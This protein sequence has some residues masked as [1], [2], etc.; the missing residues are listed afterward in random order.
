MAQYAVG[1]L[2]KGLPN[3]LDLTSSAPVLFTNAIV[4]AASLP[5]PIPSGCVV[6]PWLDTTQGSISGISISS[7]VR[8]PVKGS[9]AISVRLID[10]DGALAA[11]FARDPGF[12]NTSFWDLTTTSVDATT[13]SLSVSG[14][15]AIT[16]RIYWLEQE[17]VLVT[18]A[19]VTTGIDWALTVTRGANGS[20][21]RVHRINPAAY[22]PGEDGAFDMVSLSSRPQFE[23]FTFDADLFLM[24]IEQ[25]GVVQVV[26]TRAG[27][28]DGRPEP[29]GDAR[30]DLSLGDNTSIVADHDFGE[31]RENVT[32]RRCAQV[33]TQSG[34]PDFYI[35]PLQYTAPFIKLWVDGYEAE[36]IFNEPLH[37]P[38]NDMPVQ[39]LVNALSAKLTQDA[40]VRY[41]LKMK[42]GGYD[43]VYRATKLQWFPTVTNYQ[44]DALVVVFCA[45]DFAPINSS[46]KDNPYVSFES[47]LSSS[48]R[49]GLNSGF[50]RAAADY[51]Q[52][53]EEK[54]EIE[55]RVGIR[56][57]VVN[58]LLRL[59]HSDDGSQTTDPVYD[60]IFGRI[61]AGLFSGE[62]NQGTTPANP[63]AV[64]ETT[65]ELLELNALLPQPF[66]FIITP[67]DKFKD[68]LQNICRLHTLLFG[69]IPTSG[70]LALRFWFTFTAPASIATLNPIVSSNDLPSL[71]K[72]E[73]LA[74]VKVDV[75]Y[76]EIDLK[77]PFS[78]FVIRAKGASQKTAGNTQS[79]RL[80]IK[81][82]N[83]N[84]A[85]FV[86]SQVV[87]RLT[88]AFFRML[89]GQPEYILTATF[90]P[91]AVRTF[92]DLVLY[93]DATALLPTP[94]G[95]GIDGRYIVAGIDINLEDGRQ[96]LRLLP[97]LI[98]RT[99]SSA[100]KIA[101]SLVI[102]NVVS[103]SGPVSGVY[104]VDCEV[105]S[106]A[107][108]AFDITTAHEGIWQEL[109]NQTGRVRLY[110][111]QK[112]NPVSSSTVGVERHGYLEASALVS[113][114]LHV[115]GV[116]T[117]AIKIDES[118][119]RSGA[120]AIGDLAAAG[121]YIVLT[122]RRFAT[123]NVENVSISP[124]PFQYYDGGA[125][126]DFLKIAPSSATPPFD[127]HF[128]E[129][130]T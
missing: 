98:S 99:S 13:T 2:I 91:G 20:Y 127:N 29:T 22:G 35:S 39:S 84:F 15:A 72:L 86:M 63:Y 31:A 6:L 62:V 103:I 7:D 74:Q 128:S 102:T 121:N 69:C 108:A 123:S 60:T 57:S 51:L 125:G 58:T 77:P 23:S 30:W 126:A 65:T 59:L 49:F 40:S 21:A 100:G 107:E 67:K 117:I 19:S 43:Y 129:I 88:Q 105:D 64:E 26:Y 94:L 78:P 80:W 45:L 115:A 96:R 68:W 130:S 61:G 44:D 28:I 95:Y 14:S 76:N 37:Q 1:L 122:D 34:A 66:D 3:P 92:G 16:Q 79:V 104:T 53:D 9:A 75:G 119:L 70:A 25:G 82:T 52:E 55:F 87:W 4:D 71:E 50:S 41:L 73:P 10:V 24:Q 111:V 54:I 106:I 32:I 109:Q 46:I 93:E 56:D 89:Q 112:H 85:Q 90:L 47:G 124:I 48:P 17:A 120:V 116:N 18:S 114:I 5:A 81:T 83:P 118:W 8:D 11:L 97:D 38:G 27:F 33:I 110:N 12:Q 113:T 101:P 42:I 36:K